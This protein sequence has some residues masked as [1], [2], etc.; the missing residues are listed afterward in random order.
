MGTRLEYTG[1]EGY[2][3]FKST[4]YNT[5]T[6]E[7][8]DTSDSEAVLANEALR[9]A[10]IYAIRKHAGLAGNPRYSDARLET[11]RK[12]AENEINSALAAQYVLPLSEVPP[13]LGQI[14]ELLAAGYIDYEEFGKDGEGVKWLGEARSLIRS[15]QKGSQLLIGSDGTELGR[16]SKVDILDG[17]PDGPNTD[18]A[19]FSMADRY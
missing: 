18:A 6:A 3:Y 14:T 8:T 16:N 1:I 13:L 12:Q 9:Y 11:K 19:K 17:Y 5:E 4:Y 15:I 2:I 10:S 7:E